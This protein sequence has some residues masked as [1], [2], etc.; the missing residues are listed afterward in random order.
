MKISK[1]IIIALGIAGG[2]TVQTHAHCGACATDSHSSHD[3]SSHE[4]STDAQVL[5]LV[6]HYFSVQEALAADN[7][8][9]TKSKAQALHLGIENSGHSE[10]LM[11]IKEAVESISVAGNIMDARKAFLI[12][13]NEMIAKTEGLEIGNGE[14]LYL[15]YCPMAFNNTG[16]HW[17]QKDKTVNN[18]Y[19]GAQML[20]CGVIK[21]TVGRAE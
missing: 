12:L 1:T 7:L 17:L 6:P 11:E 9:A 5:E 21:K 3:H 19:F 14:E 2:L 4:A 8:E 13:S 18:P 20:R 15:A 16:G 10:N